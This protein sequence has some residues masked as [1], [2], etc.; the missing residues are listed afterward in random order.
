M[1]TKFRDS[2]QTP[3]NR[4][5]FLFKHLKGAVD[6]S[7]RYSVCTVALISSLRASVIK[8]PRSFLRSRRLYPGRGVDIIVPYKILFQEMVFVFQFKR[9]SYDFEFF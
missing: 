6:R 2:L 9:L 1:L 4:M 8:K 3:G 7:L 5:S